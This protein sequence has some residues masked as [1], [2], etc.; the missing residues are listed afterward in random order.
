MPPQHEAEESRRNFVMLLIGQF[1]QRSDHRCIHFL[2]EP[3]QVAG[4]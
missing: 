1:R 2:N 4:G 3:V